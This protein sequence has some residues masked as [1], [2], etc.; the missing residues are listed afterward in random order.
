[1]VIMI[2][3]YDRFLL[4]DSFLGNAWQSAS[5]QRYSTGHDGQHYNNLLYIHVVT[6]K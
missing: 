5:R 6:T 3:W 1:M 2:Y 4:R